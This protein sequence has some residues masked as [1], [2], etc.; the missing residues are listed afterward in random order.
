MT[1]ASQGFPIF[2]FMGRSRNRAAA[3]FCC[4][5]CNVLVVH[6]LKLLLVWLLLCSRALLLGGLRGWLACSLWLPK[7]NNHCTLNEGKSVD[8][9]RA[10]D[11]KFT[12]RPEPTTDLEKGGKHSGR[13]RTWCRDMSMCVPV[14]VCGKWYMYMYISLAAAAVTVAHFLINRRRTRTT[15]SLHTASRRLWNARHGGCAIFLI[16][17]WLWDFGNV[18]KRPMADWIGLMVC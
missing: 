1:S 18:P 10:E 3:R 8:G 2:F 13:P 6:T 12:V 4:C 9:G 16:L 7:K 11:G 17:C 14:C 15:P 5:C